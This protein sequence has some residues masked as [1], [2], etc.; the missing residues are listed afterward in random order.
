MPEGDTI[1][2]IAAFMAPRL[3]GQTVDN[4]RFGADA[5]GRFSG[6]TIRSHR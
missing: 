4:I 1:H 5:P 3:N 2:K 6:T